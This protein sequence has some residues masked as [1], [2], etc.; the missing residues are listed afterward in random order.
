M[1]DT[2]D[3]VSKANIGSNNQIYEGVFWFEFNSHKGQLS[4]M[5]MIGQ[6]KH[7]QT[8]EL[9]RTKIKSYKIGAF[10]FKQNCTVALVNEGKP[11]FK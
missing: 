11:I 8:L 1:F 6:I 7:I 2:F 9:D 5:T 10:L 4:M 3:Y